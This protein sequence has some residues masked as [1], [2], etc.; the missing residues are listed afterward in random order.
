MSARIS[1][2]GVLDLT[3]DFVDFIGG[4]NVDLADFVCSS[5]EACS[6]GIVAC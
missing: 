2:Q 1:V 5:T 3:E 4:L 6:N